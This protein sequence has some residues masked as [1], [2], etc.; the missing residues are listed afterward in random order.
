MTMK[1]EWVAPG[2][3][4]SAYG[5]LRWVNALGV[6]LGDADDNERAGRIDG[7]LTIAT[8]LRIVHGGPPAEYDY[9]RA[10]EAL[11]RVGLMTPAVLGRVD[12]C[13]GVAREQER[14]RLMAAPLAS[15]LVMA[16][17]MV[18]WAGAAQAGQT[19]WA[20]LEAYPAI[21]G[22]SVRHLQL[23]HTAES[24]SDEAD[25]LA[26]GQHATE[27]TAKEARGLLTGLKAWARGVEPPN[28]TVWKKKQTL[29]AASYFLEITS[30]PGQDRHLIFSSVGMATLPGQGCPQCYGV[31][32]FGRQQMPVS[33]SEAA[34]LIAGLE[35]WVGGVDPASGSVW[36][37]IRVIE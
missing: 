26:R 21:P 23:S 27:I 18:L 16:L 31:V 1:S 8:D 13:R 25:M 35:T 15:R 6:V 7:L 33:E 30:R 34:D 24:Y 2:K 37:K 3:G 20:D 14:E 4:D 17:A 36:S 10:L 5:V 28:Q 9:E 32:S 11:D 19:F 12:F 29:G 22:W